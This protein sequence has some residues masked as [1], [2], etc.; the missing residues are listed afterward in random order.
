M[1]RRS[2]LQ[3]DFERRDERIFIDI[4]EPADY[5]APDAIYTSPGGA[6]SEDFSP[7]EIPRTRGPRRGVFRAE[8]R[9][10]EPIRRE[11]GGRKITDT[12]AQVSTPA[13]NFIDKF[14]DWLNKILGGT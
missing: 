13:K 3:R 12:K 9:G 14:F 5:T 4:V 1:I 7:R 2:R 11:P 6:V 10:G 8:R